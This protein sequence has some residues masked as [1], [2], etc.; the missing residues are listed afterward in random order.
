MATTLYPSVEEA[1][2]I[3]E[4]L[5]NKFGGQ[6]GLRDLGLLESALNRPRSGYYKTLFEQAAAI[7]HSL[8][9]NHC[10]IDGNKRIAITLAITFLK[11]NGIKIKLESKRTEQFIINRIINGRA[12]VEEIALFLADHVRK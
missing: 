11:V 10:F 12:D 4:I 9:G 7:M 3:H 1:I 8:L 2:K 6:H 5:I